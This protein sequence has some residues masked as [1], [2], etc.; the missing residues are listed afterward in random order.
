MSVLVEPV[1]G[2]QRI[3]HE[4]YYSELTQG[5]HS[6]FDLGTFKFEMGETL[7]RAR[8]AYKTVGKLNKARDNAILF[9]HMYS[10]TSASM[11]PF[12]GVGRP[13]DPQQYFI[14][15][16]GQFG[17]GFSSSPSNT[18][19]PFDRAR[20]PKV[21]I[22]DDVRAQYRLVTEQLN[23][24]KL[25]LVLGWSMGAEQTYEWAV[26][27][28][29][30]V[31]RAAT[32]GGTA[33]TTPHNDLF[34]RLHE[35]AIWSDPAWDSGDYPDPSAVKAGLS[36]HAHVFSVMG[37]CPAFYKQ[38]A[39]RIFGSNSLEEFIQNFWEAWFLPM[40]PNNLLCMGWKW[41]HGDVSRLFGGDLKKALA[42]IQAKTYV[43]PF[44]NDMFFPAEDCAAEQALIKGSELRVIDS[45][46]AHFAM[47]CI[48]PADQQQ[49][50]QN[51]A[52]LLATPV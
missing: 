3:N 24:D 14:I 39:W 51:L 6:Y 23:I 18:P 10:G 34:V 42:Q 43:M 4:N 8:L 13:L 32:F 17:N 50:D 21:T 29:Q 49:I 38:E 44:A 37:T 47:L 5:P 9:P 7:P 11:E 22:G 40:D 45:L 26:R 25:Q 19:A 30:M 27:Y 28:P 41:R 46:W 48:D 31:L 33:K 16:P 1:S 2:G 35:E 36:L 20:F 12:I 52:E 15:L